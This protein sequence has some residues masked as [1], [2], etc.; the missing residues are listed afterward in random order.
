MRVAR[1]LLSVNRAFLATTTGFTHFHSSL[2]GVGPVSARL[3]QNKKG[4]KIKP[5][6]EL[7]AALG[8]KKDAANKWV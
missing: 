7:I 3:A 2:K 4:A 5:L 6:P 1:N 8:A